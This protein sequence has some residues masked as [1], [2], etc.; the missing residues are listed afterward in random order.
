MKQARTGV[1]LCQGGRKRAESPEYKRLRC[2]AEAAAGDGPVY[3]ITQA[4][5]A[6]GAA[7]VVRL[8]REHELD[9]FILGACPLATSGGPLQRELIQ[10]G[11]D[12]GAV[13]VLDLCRKPQEGLGECLVVD[14][15]PK[16]LGQALAAQARFQPLERRLK[17]VCT[18]VLVLG[19]GLLALE[20]A[21]DLARSGY[22]VILL[23]PGKR[24][25]PPQPLLGPRAAVR[26]AELAR[27][28]EGREQV[29]IMTRGQLLSLAGSA[30][31]FQA[32]LLDG[33]GGRH[34]RRLGAVLVAQGPPLELNQEG[35]GLEPGPR[36]KSL[37]ELVSLAGAPEHLRQV[38]GSDAPRIALVLGLARESGPLEL[39][40]ACRIGLELVRERGAEV[41]L[42]VGNLKVAA[43]DL[44]MLSQELRSQGAPLF[45]LEAG[46][47]RGQAGV[48]GVK[49]AFHE[50]ILDRDLELHF[51]LVALDQMAA[52]DDDYR[53]LARALGLVVQGDGC[54]QP[55]ALN[56]LPTG[57]RRAGVFL[58]GP[59]RGLYD[60]D[61]GLDQVRE[62]VG[63]VRR[64]LRGG[65][66]WL[67][68]DRVRVD[69]KRCT[70]CLTCVRVCP[71][72]AM[73][74]RERRPFY[75]PLACTGCG[76]CAAECPM[77]AIQLVNL[78]DDRFLAEIEAAVTGVSPGLTL[79]TGRELAV[80]ACANSA[81]RALSAARLAGRSWPAG[82]RLIQVPCAGKIDPLYLLDALRQGFDQ[83]LVLSCHQDACYSLEGSSWLRWR[84]EHLGRL[85]AEAGYDP[86]RIQLEGVAPAMAEEVMDLVEQAL[87]K[88]REQEPSPL[89]AGARVRDLLER[90]TVS[91]DADYTIRA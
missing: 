17:E 83:V 63:R 55:E 57:S 91:M 12:P 4:C 23:V 40:A 39:R 13:Q 44:E 9:S 27:E 70:I 19:Q 29:E 58:L 61:S 84:V 5:Q 88:T 45:K 51:D 43:P 53:R 60:L 22:P 3:E 56:A 77:D 78:D 64:L 49:L 73:R 86:G 71:Q 52:P 35:L 74:F 33:Q 65:E 28:L 2:T 81:G 80:F 75:N 10:A 6:E 69:R 1:F 68:A 66:V 32:R 31:D 16:A 21:R 18:T 34:R 62:A 47:L 30:G 67:E 85:L 46:G 41:A 50:D 36:V 76:T 72:G 90:F 38:T 37:A 15:G 89:K 24:L 87:Q 11:L 82:A 25:A 79:E 7:A 48:D 42:L 26:A 20:A 14:D 8:A 54:L 59:A